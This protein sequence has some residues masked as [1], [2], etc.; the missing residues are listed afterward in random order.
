MTVATKIKEELLKAGVRV[1]D[2]YDLVNTSKPYPEAIP[3]LVSMLREDI[4]DDVIKEGVIRALAVKE[5][6]GMAGAVLIDVFHKT[7]KTKELIRWAVGNTMNSVI[8]KE[9]VPK[10]CAIVRDKENG[11]SREMFVQSLGKVKTA[12]TEEVLI[13]LLDDEE[14][15]LHAV[16]A[17]GRQKSQQAKEKL[18]LLLGHDEPVIRREAQKALNRIG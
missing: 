12:A 8:T 15:V 16:I 13:G 2:I 6:K 1:N 18:R 4:P 10:V 3:V 9:D 5:A 17:L 14:V 11:M 7:P